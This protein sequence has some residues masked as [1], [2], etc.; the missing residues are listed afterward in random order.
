MEPSLQALPYPSLVFGYQFS[1][2][3]DNYY[4]EELWSIK[5][6]IYPRP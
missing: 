5:I 2:T 3:L 1:G 6:K 4:S